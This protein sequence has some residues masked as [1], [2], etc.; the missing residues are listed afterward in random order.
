MATAISNKINPTIKP[1]PI[2]EEITIPVATEI[3]GTASVLEFSVRSRSSTI[4]QLV[5]EAF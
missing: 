4:S 5:G 2:N 3:A 1:F